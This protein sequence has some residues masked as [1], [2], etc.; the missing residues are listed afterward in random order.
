[1]QEQETI[2]RSPFTRVCFYKKK[3]MFRA[4]IRK[5]S[6]CDDIIE[7]FKPLSSES[8]RIF[9]MISSSVKALIYPHDGQHLATFGETSSYY[10]LKNIKQRME[11]D[12]T[13]LKILK[14]KPRIRSPYVDFD[15]LRAL[16]KDTFGKTYIDHMDDLNLDPNQR[17]LVKHIADLDLAYI[18]QRYKEIHDFIHLILLKDISE[19]SEIEVKFY[20]FQQL[21]LSS[22]ALSALIGPLRLSWSENN[23]LIRGGAQKMIEKANTSKFCMNVY[24]EKHFD[25]NIDEFREWFFTG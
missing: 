23:R 5:A 9:T 21:G 25:K 24:Y 1:M 10:A 7:N 4:L 17:P 8:E 14:E 12:P 22:T 16:P 11:A 20:E 6:S 15:K 3:N 18:F 2:T 13:G 19:N